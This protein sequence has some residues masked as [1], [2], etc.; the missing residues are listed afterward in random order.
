MMRQNSARVGELII[1]IEQ[2]KY[3]IEKTSFIN[4]VENTKTVVKL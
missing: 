4:R 3:R 2:V 1:C